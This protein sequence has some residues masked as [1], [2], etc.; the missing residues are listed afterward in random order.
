MKKIKLNNSNYYTLV[1]NEDYFKLNIRNWH[2]FNGYAHGKINNKTVRMHRLVMN[3]Q[4]GD[5]LEIDHINGNKLDNRKINLRIVTHMQN[6]WNTPRFK[7]S[8]TGYKGVSERNGK[9]RV[10]ISVNNKN[11]DLGQ[12]DFPDV[13]FEV[14]KA[15]VFYYRGIYGRT[16]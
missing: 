2:Y 9:F 13:A 11:V 4:V 5:G 10:R 6:M 1:D 3:L 12:Y 16:E 15:A 14:Y 7:N 8:R